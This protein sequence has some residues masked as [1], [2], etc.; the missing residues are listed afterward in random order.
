M[1]RW[2]A[3]STAFHGKC[4]A[5]SN[6][7]HKY[8]RPRV[9]LNYFYQSGTAS[10][11]LWGLYNHANTELST[12]CHSVTSRSM[13]TYDH[14]CALVEHSCITRCRICTEMLLC[15]ELPYYCIRFVSERK[16]NWHLLSNDDHNTKHPVSQM[17]TYL[18]IN[19]W[20]L[21]EE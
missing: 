1:V 3:P 14:K 20:Y 9:S 16:L 19:H 10:I 15:W 18:L 7:R 21:A 5:K 13:S 6:N 11:D 4:T 17:M 12:D 2:V 8:M